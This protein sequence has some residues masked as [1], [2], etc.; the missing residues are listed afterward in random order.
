MV[1]ATKKFPQSYR[2]SK[3]PGAKE[4]NMSEGNVLSLGIDL[5]T[6]QS[7]I[8]SSTGVR[9]TVQSVVGWP[10]DLV[11]QKL[12][13]KPIVFG[14][15]ALKHRLAVDLYYP[16]ERG[17]IKKGTVRDEEA[18]MQL[19]KHL[20][21]MARP[22]AGEKVHVV[23][24]APAEASVVDQQAL[25]DGCK[26]FVDA[27]MVVS[28]PFTVAYGLNALDNSL[29]IDIGAGTVDLCRMHGTF[30][31][32]ADQRTLF[33]AGNYVDQK[34][35]EL[36]VEKHPEG[37]ITQLMAKRAKEQSGL[38]SAAKGVV[39]L[40]FPVAGVPFAHDVT[41][42]LQKACEG[43]VP[44]IL[45]SMTDLIADHDPDFQE[46]LRQNVILAGGGSQMRG[47]AQLIEEYLKELGGGKVRV[48]DDYVYCGANGALLLAQEADRAYWHFL[49][50]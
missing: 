33:K 11:S 13:K 38:V 14:D 48:V 45:E 21:E 39:Q 34:F 7:S 12:I 31:H 28:E 20:V 10:R 4:A 1:K 18:A 43:I 50:E 41:E 19:I 17:V 24:G 23:I 32:E 36:L 26:E 8:A 22:A 37:K 27:V 25:I 47:L 35:Y 42:E 5:G 44:D 16:L 6:S 46:T 9:R 29:V 15:E 40:T 49:K 3:A 30:P 2:P